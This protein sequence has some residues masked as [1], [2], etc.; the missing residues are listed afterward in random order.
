MKKGRNPQSEGSGYLRKVKAE[1]QVMGVTLAV[2][3]RWQILP[4]R[5]GTW[6]FQLFKD[7]YAKLSMWQGSGS[8]RNRKHLLNY[9]FLQTWLPDC[10]I[11]KISSH[12]LAESELRKS[13]TIY[14]AGTFN[15][16]G[17]VRYFTQ[18]KVN[19]SWLDRYWKRCCKLKFKTASEL[20]IRL[21]P[22]RTPE[23]A[24]IMWKSLFL[25]FVMHFT[26]F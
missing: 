12:Q 19:N 11:F 15:I 13:N 26:F 23:S 4:C 20:F 17:P 6:S 14:F 10:A 2:W 3:A 21:Q 9:S 7:V 24:S 16:R 1:L 5:G 25:L 22:S 8:Y 18:H